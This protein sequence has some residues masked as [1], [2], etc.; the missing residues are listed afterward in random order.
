MR[1][2]NLALNGELRLT[3]RI[4]LYIYIIGNDEKKPLQNH[5]PR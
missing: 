1:K 3:L 2:R 5:E 4:K